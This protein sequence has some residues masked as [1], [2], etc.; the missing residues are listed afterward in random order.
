M[1]LHQLFDREW[2]FDLLVAVHSPIVMRRRFEVAD[3]AGKVSGLA[4]RSLSLRRFAWRSGGG[5]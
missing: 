3:R 4:L 5:G 1:L 2:L